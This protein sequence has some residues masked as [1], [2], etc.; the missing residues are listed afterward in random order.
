MLHRDVEIIHRRFDATHRRVGIA[1][2]QPSRALQ[3]QAGGE[4]TLDDGVVEVLRNALT[5][6]DKREGLHSAVETGV[7]D[8]DPGCGRESDHELFVDVGERLR[9]RLVGE[10]QVAEHL[11]AHPHGHAQERSHRGVV[12]GKAEAVR[13]LP[14][15]G[16]AQRLGVHDERTEDP[17]P[18]GQVTDERVHV[19]VD[20]HGDEL[21]EPCAG[22]VEHAQRSVAGIDQSDRRL[23]DP[24]EHRQRI[25]IRTEGEH[26]GK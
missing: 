19:V 1:L 6:F 13:V 23:D 24:S 25:E 12:S 11:V 9:G 21:R 14:Q 10:V 26:G 5:V 4:K 17:E 18:L 8:G 15:V 16:Q 3:R 20:P 2:H 22:V 7:L